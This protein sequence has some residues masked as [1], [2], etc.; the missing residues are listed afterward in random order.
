MI[1]YSYSL[2]FILGSLI[3]AVCTANTSIMLSLSVC[4]IG[5]AMAETVLSFN[6]D[7]RI[8]RS[9]IGFF[10]IAV[11][12]LLQSAAQGQTIKSSLI[13]IY[14]S[15]SLFLLTF[16][17]ISIIKPKRR[18]LALVVVGALSFLGILIAYFQVHQ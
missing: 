13:P 15:F 9:S 7:S 12:G 4:L 17:A 10:T 1:K 5:L 18:I 14:L 3:V 11:L 8:G 6:V 16:F 2:L